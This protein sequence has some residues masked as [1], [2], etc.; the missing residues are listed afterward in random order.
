MTFDVRDEPPS[1]IDEYASIPIAFEVRSVLEVDGDGSLAERPVVPWVKDYDAAG[2]SPRDWPLRFDV[3]RW[4]FL[5]ARSAGRAVGAAA[6]VRDAPDVDM[7]EGRRDLALIWDIRVAPSFRGRGVGRALFAAAEALARDRGCRELMVE[8][9]NVN[10][11]ACR[12]YAAN[13]CVLARVR[14]GAY[15]ELPGEVQLIWSK[16]LAPARSADGRA[17]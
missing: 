8:T 16:D 10:V 13:G 11:P 12:F 14:R 7:L 17:G 9:Q 2:E 1:V 5:I 4:R 6:V 3:S 15:A